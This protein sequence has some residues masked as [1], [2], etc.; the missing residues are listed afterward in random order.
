MAGLLADG[1]ESC[2]VVCKSAVCMLCPVCF[3]G[4][5]FLLTFVTVVL[6]LTGWGT[7][8]GRLTALLLGRLTVLLLSLLV[9]QAAGSFLDEVHDEVV[10]GGVGW[11]CVV[12]T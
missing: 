5:R 12:W 10:G 1:V 2:S 11:V 9:A 8:G 3:C 7:A 6:L 4:A